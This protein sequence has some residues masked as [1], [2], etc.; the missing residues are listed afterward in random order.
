MAN[1]PKLVAEDVVV[2]LDY[3]LTVNGEIIDSTKD[4]YPLEY[5]QGHHNIIP[6]LE[7][8]LMGLSIG[9]TK[10]VLVPCDEAYGQVNPNAFTDVSRSQFPEGFELIAGR[11]L[12]ISTTS[13]R[14]MTATIAE[15]NDETVKLDLNHP[16]AGKDLLFN[17][18]IVG[19]RTVTEDEL[20]SGQVG[21]GGCGSSCGDSCGSSCGSGCC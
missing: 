1:E 6:G 12:R 17:A 3:T 5:I 8:A 19:L 14:L 2:S 18:S 20:I 16:L 15:F 7:N 11:S 10:E 13:G 4:S 21:G 9:E